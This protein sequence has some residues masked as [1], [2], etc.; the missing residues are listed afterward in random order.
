[1]VAMSPIAIRLLSPLIFCVTKKKAWHCEEH[2]ARYFFLIVSNE[3]RKSSVIYTFTARG[4]TCIQCDVNK[5][6][7]SFK[8][9]LCT[10]HSLNMLPVFKAFDSLELHLTLHTACACGVNGCALFF[11]TALKTWLVKWGCM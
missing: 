1:M 8:N 2:A 5:R 10:I 9:V 7:E 6:W 11:Y 4:Q 3:S